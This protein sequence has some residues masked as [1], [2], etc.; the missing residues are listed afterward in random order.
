MQ[1][2]YQHIGKF[3]RLYNFYINGG[4]VISTTKKGS[5]VPFD[6]ALEQRYNRCANVSGGIIEG[7]RKKADVVMREII[8]HKNT[9]TL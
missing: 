7:T 1:D 3:S 4:F 2:C 9:S 6:Q 5:V 8:K